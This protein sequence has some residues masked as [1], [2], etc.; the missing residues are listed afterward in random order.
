M[1]HVKG[2]IVGKPTVRLIVIGGVLLVAGSAA[3]YHVISSHAS[4]S[5]VGV[6][7]S[8]P[9]VKGASVTASNTPAP[10]AQGASVTPSPVATSTAK[11]SSGGHTAAPTQTQ[12]PA[13]GSFGSVAPTPT[14]ITYLTAVTQCYGG[15]TMSNTDPGSSPYWIK[16]C[17]L[18]NP[19]CTT[20]EGYGFCAFHAAS[21]QQT[22]VPCTL[23]GSCPSNSPIYPDTNANDQ[24][25]PY[26]PGWCYGGNPP[27]AGWGD[28]NIHQQYT[29][30][31]S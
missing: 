8:A 24:I 15:L 25:L 16:Y 17:T 31:C 29:T 18:Y 5:R 22:D 1:I 9:A 7:V 30:D 3:A 20:W 26:Q 19:T 28:G 6:A 11:S 21:T 27:G 2:L 10:T 12:V 4:A 13:G 23:G 14:P